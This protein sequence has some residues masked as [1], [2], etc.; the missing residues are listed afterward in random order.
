LLSPTPSPPRRDPTPRLKSEGSTA[1]R[2]DF[3]TSLRTPS[4]AT[5]V[6]KAPSHSRTNTY[7]SSR[8]NSVPLPQSPRVALRD[9][10]EISLL[11]PDH[12]LDRDHDSDDAITLVPSLRRSSSGCCSRNQRSQR[13]TVYPYPTGPFPGSALPSLQLIPTP[14]LIEASMH[15]HLS[16]DWISGASEESTPS[17]TNSSSSSPSRSPSLSPAEPLPPTRLMAPRVDVDGKSDSPIH[18]LDYLNLVD[19]YVCLFYKVTYSDVDVLP[20]LLLLHRVGT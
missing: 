3:A 4:R 1:A 17:I 15:Q 19:P 2:Y 9:K 6:S 18:N 10:T 11:S 14:S 8:P 12:D 20:Q 5:S 16:Q 13:T 7:P